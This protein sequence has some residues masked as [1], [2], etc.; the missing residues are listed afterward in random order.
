MVFLVNVTEVTLFVDEVN[1]FQYMQSFDIV[2]CCVSPVP[3][4][5]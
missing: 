4:P 3:C 5:L 2:M 1:I